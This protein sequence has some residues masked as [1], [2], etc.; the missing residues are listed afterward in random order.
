MNACFFNV[1]HNTWDKYIFAVADSICFQFFTDDVFV[2]Q[3][4]LVFVYQYSCLQ[5]FFQVFIRVNNLHCTAAQNIG[6]TNKHRITDSVCNF[7][8]VRNVCNSLS[9]RFRNAQS[10]HDF[11]KAVTVFCS[12]DSVNVCTN[13]WHTQFFQVVC[14]V[15]SCLTAKGY[16]NTVRFFHIDNVHYIFNCQWFKVQFVSCCIVCGNCFWVV[17]DDN[18]FVACFFD[19]PYSVNCGVVK[20]NTLAD[21]DW[22]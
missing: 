13:N 1:F 19:S 14:Q 3:N 17:V 2:N 20:F 4:R 22:A 16:D 7:D 18:S 9:F 11:F 12:F 5:V 10:V 21:S 15:D 6:R 8:T